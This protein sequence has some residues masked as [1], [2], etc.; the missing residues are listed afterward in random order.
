YYQLRVKPPSFDLAF[1]QSQLNEHQSVVEYLVDENQVWAFVISMDKVDLLPLRGTLNLAKLVEQL[2]SSLIGPDQAQASAQSYTKSAS[3]LYDCLVNPIESHLNAELIIIP[4]DILS[5]LPFECLLSE[6]ASPLQASH[7]L[8]FWLKEKTISYA[9]SANL[10]VNSRNKR[11]FAPKRLLAVAPKF[12][13]QQSEYAYN[14]GDYLGPLKSSRAEA[15]RVAQIWQGETLLDSMASVQ[16]FEALASQ[17]QIIHL[18]THGKILDEGTGRSFLAFYGPE[19]TLRLGER[20]Y[21]QVQA[22]YLS[23]L[24]SLRLRSDLVVLSACET[25][26]G[27]LYKGEGVASL[28]R[29]FTYAGAASIINTLWSVSDEGSKILMERFYYHLNQSRSRAEAL[30]LAKLDLIETRPEFGMPFYWAGYIL[31]GDERKLITQN[32]GNGILYLLLLISFAFAV[33][34][35]LQSQKQK[36]AD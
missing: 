34:M 32:H 5:Y 28:A 26:L 13:R 30:R 29:G 27:K 24:F 33:G 6:A 19:D 3:E 21:P 2:R 8:P 36:T 7:Q 9:Y 35:L 18:A 1:I 4:D 25:G 22:L 14:R 31:V 17:Y 20:S 16:N 23:E 10:W 11:R 15:Q 12:E